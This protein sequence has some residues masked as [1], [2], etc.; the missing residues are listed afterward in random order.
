ML[1]EVS[2]CSGSRIST[3]SKELRCPALLGLLPEMSDDLVVDV[4]GIVVGFGA[5]L[6]E[7][8]HEGSSLR[9]HIVHRDAA[10]ESVNF[11]RR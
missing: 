8:L 1:R 5:A 11:C 3:S 9:A 10:G 2:T 6:R 4:L 7:A